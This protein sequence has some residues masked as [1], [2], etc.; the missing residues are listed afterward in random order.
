VETL[1]RWA[2][3]RVGRMVLTG[4]VHSNAADLHRF[5][6]ALFDTEE[7]ASKWKTA[8][9]GEAGIEAQARAVPARDPRRHVKVTWQPVGQGHK[10]RWTVAP[11]EDVGA[12]QGAAL[13]EFGWL[14]A[15]K[16]EPFTPGYRP[17]V[18]PGDDSAE[19]DR[20][21]LAGLAESS[22][23]AAAW[24]TERE[25]VRPGLAERPPDG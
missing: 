13:A 8:Q 2:S 7:I 6:P 15:W 20:E 24:W 16:V 18:S 25:A 14:V 19:L 5:H 10:E 9:G 4:G 1:Q 3:D 22:P 12:Y 11:V 21:V 23:P 17:A